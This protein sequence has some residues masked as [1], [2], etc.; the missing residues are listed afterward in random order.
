[1]VPDV[2][3]TVPKDVLE[4]EW[5]SGV[6]AEMGNTLTPT[7][8][9]NPPKV[10]WQAEEGALYTLCMT[11]PDAPSRKTPKYREW[12]HWLVVNIP[13][14]DVKQGEVLSAY[15]GSG[16]PKDSGLHRYVIILYKQP[17]KLRC[18]EARLTNK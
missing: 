4:V 17:K 13:G 18:D 9:K 1:M 3:D 8:V 2:L 11:D 7:N 5:K 14:T 6:K 10:R 16:P 12:H 15:I